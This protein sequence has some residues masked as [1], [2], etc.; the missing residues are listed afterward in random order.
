MQDLIIKLVTLLNSI[1]EFL[2]A[3][4]DSLIEQLPFAEW[5]IDAI[6]DSIHM[7]PFLFVIFVIIEV[8]EFFCSYKITQI[9][10]DS[11]K[12]GPLTGSLVASF[13]QCGFSIIASTL[14]TKRFITKGTLLAVYLS[15]SDEAIPVILSYPEKIHYVVPL[16]L[17]KIVIAIIAG[18]LIDFVLDNAKTNAPN[19]E[20]LNIEEAE[21]CCKHH[22]ERPRKRDLLYHP[23][24]HTVNV[25]IFILLITLGLNYL[26]EITGGEENLSKI[27][28]HNSIF[29]P[30]ICAIAG[31]IPN[32]AISVAITMMYL[33]GAIGFGSTIAGLSSGAGLGLLVLLKKN[34]LKDTIK[35]ILLLL[36]IS[37]FSGIII[38][39]V[40]N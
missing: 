40:Y 19:N 36:A 25:F 38:Q 31:L 7:L 13:P 32:C 5:I 9:A 33:K 2:F 24:Q 39:A 30:I 1:N 20:E 21:G 14:Y 4:I 17:T 22:V 28:L 8:I 35:I 29:Q 3:R 12:T 16:L 11:Q 15:T 37:M 23:I 18:Y 26:V 10:K 6:K 27:F 34:P